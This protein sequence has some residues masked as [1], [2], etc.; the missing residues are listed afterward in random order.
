MSTADNKRMARNT[1]FLY[2]RS[3]VSMVI[4]LYTSRKILEILGVIVQ[5]LGN[6]SRSE[7]AAEYEANRA[8]YDNLNK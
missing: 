7:I 4:S 8:F 2:L 3:F 6:V 5:K 1:I